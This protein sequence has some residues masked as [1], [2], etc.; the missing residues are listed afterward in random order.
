MRI[1]PSPTMVHVSTTGTGA[2]T[3]Y[4]SAGAAL[5]LAIIDQQLRSRGVAITLDSSAGMALALEIIEQNPR[6][7][8]V[9]ITLDSSAGVALGLAIT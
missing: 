3:P 2:R 8:G 1:A 7:R 4:S 5:G 9:A 6:S